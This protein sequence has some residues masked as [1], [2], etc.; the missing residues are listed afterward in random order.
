VVVEIAHVNY[1]LALSKNK[2]I[3]EIPYD[4]KTHPETPRNC[5]SC[6]NSPVSS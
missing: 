6:Q 1:N 2:H 5:R 3:A 4:R